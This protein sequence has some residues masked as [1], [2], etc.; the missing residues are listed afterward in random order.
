MVNAIGVLPRDEA[1]LV[2]G[3]VAALLFFAIPE[4]SNKREPKDWVLV[5]LIVIGVYGIFLKFRLWL[6]S[7][8]DRR[9]AMALSVLLILVFFVCLLVPNL[10]KGGKIQTS[11]AR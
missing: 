5:L 3:L 6:A 4:V 7:V 9:I 2:S 1:W 10:R 8:I 11:D